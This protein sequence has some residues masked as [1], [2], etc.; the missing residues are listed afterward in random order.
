[1]PTNVLLRRLFAHAKAKG[2]SHMAIAHALNIHV[3]TVSNWHGGMPPNE[4]NAAA[5]TKLLRRSVRKPK[6]KAPAKAA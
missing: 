1:M 5:I 6:A 3:N 2:L 4:V